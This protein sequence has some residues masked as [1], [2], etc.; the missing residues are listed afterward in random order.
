FAIELPVGA[1]FEAPT[2]ATLA[3]R[4]QAEQAGGQAQVVGPIERAPADERAALSFA[5]QRLWFLDQWRPGGA[6]YN[7]PAA[8]RLSGVLDVPA[9]ERSLGEV[10]RRHEVLRTSFPSE[11][12]QPAQVVA[13]DPAFRLALTDLSG[14]PEGER[15]AEAQRLAEEEARAPFDLAAG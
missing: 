3:R 5:Q 6:V 7:L 2:V 13:A 8:R 1:L 9:L 11:R 14:L 10:G 15:E 4:I 12:G